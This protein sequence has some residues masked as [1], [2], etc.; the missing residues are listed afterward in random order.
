M[1]GSCIIT[2]SLGTTVSDTPF[3]CGSKEGT[4]GIDNLF[5]FL[6]DMDEFRIYNRELSATAVS[7][8][9]SLR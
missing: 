4:P 9:Y 7:S 1:N 5:P 3:H 6:G 8:L 2:Q